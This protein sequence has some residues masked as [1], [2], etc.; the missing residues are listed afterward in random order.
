MDGIP[1]LDP[2]SAGRLLAARRVRHETRCE[3]CGAPI[4]ATRR[5]RFCSGTCS[6]RAWRRRH[7]GSVGGAPVL[8]V[9]GDP[10]FT[11]ALALAFELGGL[12]PVTAA[13]VSEAAG[14]VRR[15]RPI[16]VLLDHSSL[17]MD[18]IAAALT[19]DNGAH[20][21]PLV[22]MSAEVD[23]EQIARSIG[24]VAFLT[25][26]LDVTRLLADVAEISRSA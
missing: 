2:T 18:R 16:V 14:A 22:L 23:T 19:P 13:S 26:P 10:L 17:A 12:Q 21:A 15:W 20:R 9:D 7:A 24:A 5:R 25:K 11:E 6:V 1:G 4:E 3:E 8:I